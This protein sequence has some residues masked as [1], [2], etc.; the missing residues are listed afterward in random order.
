MTRKVGM[1]W[2]LLMALGPWLGPADAAPVSKKHTPPKTSAAVETVQ[3]YVA[4]M[5]AG[6][7]VAAGK[8]DF[9]CAY[10]LATA[11]GSPPDSGQPAARPAASF[12]PDSDP[13]YSAC[14]EPVA[15]AHAAVIQQTDQGVDTL[16]PGKGFLVVFG[17][18]LARYPPSLFVMDT[19]GASPPA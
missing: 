12:P 6:D 18:N 16:W 4:A 7:K 8:L 1:A 5:A 13:L 3:R 11:T 15:K 17:E 10:R 14:W 2:G 19:L 9:A